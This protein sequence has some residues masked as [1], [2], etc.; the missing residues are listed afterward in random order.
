MKNKVTDVVNAIDLSKKTVSK[1][2]QNLFFSLFYNVIGIP[3]AARVFIGLGIVL[4]PELAGLAM[5]LS[6]VSVVSNS[7]LLRRFRPNYRNWIST[8]APIVMTGAFTVAFIFLA[9][10]STM[11][12]G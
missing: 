9:R 12:S 8:L 5:A 6:S 1:I 11:T 3:I 4:R 10:I 7:L 2:K